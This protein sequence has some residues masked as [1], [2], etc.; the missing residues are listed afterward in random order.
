M[1]FILWGDGSVAFLKNCGLNKRHIFYIFG[2][3]FILIPIFF[4]N[5][6]KMRATDMSSRA[7]T[8]GMPQ[9]SDGFFSDSM[10]VE[11]LTSPGN[12]N[13]NLPAIAANGHALTWDGR[14]FIGTSHVRS[15]A[16]SSLSSLSPIKEVAIGILKS[17]ESIQFSGFTLIM[18]GDG[19]LVLY[20]NG[21][22]GGARWATGTN[23]KCT[24]CMAAFQGDGNLVIYELDAQDSVVKPVYSTRTGDSPGA[25]FLFYS[26]SPYFAIMNE[27]GKAVYW[28]GAEQ[29]SG[30]AARVF[31]PEA[32]SKFNPKGDS[33]TATRMQESFSPPFEWA[34]AGDGLSDPNKFGHVEVLPTTSLNALALIPNSNFTE[35]PFRSDESGR[36]LDGGSYLTYKAFI[37]SQNDPEKNGKYRLG[38]T[39]LT[40]V[41]KNPYSESANIHRMITNRR[42]DELRDVTGRPILAL[43]PTAV[44]DGRLLVYQNWED[45]ANR[46]LLYYTTRQ[47][48]PTLQMGWSAPKSITEMTKDPELH[49]RYP[50]ARYPLRDSRGNEFRNSI[51][52]AYPW[53]SLDGTDL[54]FDYTAHDDGARRAGAVIAGSST[55]GLVR[56]IDGG[57]NNSRRG[58]MGE[59]NS[60]HGEKRPCNTANLVS[61]RLFMS[62]LGRTPGMWSP[63]EFTERKVL[64]FTDKLYT[65]PMF[66]SN[67]SRYF[68]VSLEESVVGNYDLYLEMSEGLNQS[69]DYDIGVTPDVSGKFFVPQL[70]AGVKYAE[71]L[72]AD[73]TNRICPQN[74]FQN[75][76][77]PLFSGKALYFKG[78]GLITVNSTSATGFE[79]LK[80]AEDLTISLAVRPT[81]DLGN[82]NNEYRILVHKP[83][84]FHIILEAN[85]QIQTTVSFK[86]QD[87]SSEEV[88]SGFV[89]P[90]L[91]LNEWSHVAMTYSRAHGVMRTFVNGEVVGE[92]SIP[93]SYVLNRTSS[94]LL[95][96][97]SRGAE[98]DIIFALDQVG[99]SRVVR[100][101][102]ELRRQAQLR[103][104][105]SNSLSQNLPLGLKA[106]DVRSDAFFDRPLNSARVDLGRFLF[107]DKRLSADNRTS[108]ATCHDPNLGFAERIALHPSRM[109]S[110]GQPTHLLRNS[111]SLI[112]LAF[113]DRFFADGRAG[114]LIEQANSV[115]SNPHE[116][117]NDPQVI[118]QKLLGSK[119]YRDLFGTVFPG[120][121]QPINMDNIL[122]SLMEFELSLTSGGSR[123]DR[124]LAGELTALNSEERKG[125]ALFFGKA[126]CA[127]CHSG[128]AFTDNFAHNVGLPVANAFN[129]VDLGRFGFSKGFDD[130]SRYQTPSLRNIDLSAPY[131]HGGSM[132]SLEEVIVHYN[133]IFQ[134]AG[135]GA[136][137]D[138]S[139]IEIGL[140]GSEISSL[141]SFLRALS[142]QPPAV[143]LPSYADPIIELPLEKRFEAGSLILQSN[144]R[145]ELAGGHLVFQTNG[146]LAF[147]DDL[148]RD[149]WKSNSPK[150]CNTPNDC[151]AVWQGDGNLVLY[152]KGKPYWETTT[153]QSHVRGQTLVVSVAN[154]HLK[155]LNS[156]NNLVWS[157]NGGIVTPAPVCAAGSE[158]TAGCSQPSN[159]V[160]KKTCNSQGTAYGSC[161]MT[162]NA[163]YS[164]NGSSCILNPPAQ[165]CSPGSQ[166]T[167]GCTPQPTNGKSERT[168]NSTGTAYGVCYIS[169]NAN[170]KPTNA[171]TCVA[172]PP[173]TTVRIEFFSILTSQVSKTLS[174]L[175]FVENLFRGVLGRSSDIGGLS[176]HSGKL[177]ANSQSREDLRI[178]FV[179]SSEFVLTV[180]PQNNRMW[181]KVLYKSIL[182]RESDQG[183]EDFWTNELDSRKLTRNQVI[184]AFLA[185]PEYKNVTVKD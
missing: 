152:H 155:I 93:S 34:V 144:E 102:A 88:R 47:E 73:C 138:D 108:C 101:Q 125:R 165:V 141:A 121:N 17:Q 26:V 43:E 64:P 111:P 19:N 51:P 128:S 66:A 5:C 99:V 115:L 96:G 131:F 162:C 2:L 95:V 30:W 40:I 167:N 157:S 149:L 164:P 109:G 44:F 61:H 65:Y 76:A 4:Q 150:D 8:S 94:S 54:F 130:R 136:T 62:S 75:P 174:N 69:G 166:T 14:I 145:V 140:N 11:R 148:N 129:V 176:S 48:G 114:S 178:E 92:K 116:M 67:S 41:V 77:V 74:D 160:S 58:C 80:D 122:S 124:Y 123:F 20:E 118:V 147:V 89:G 179:G 107:F 60:L 78:G 27:S 97:S 37:V 87:G 68:E 31:R 46:G 82:G 45:N 143:S 35:N 36:S 119:Q 180:F 70:N 50:F 183:G 126:R 83:D 16:P 168:C 156:T 32:L 84:S 25:R 38:L 181:V 151:K 134:K 153:W 110:F 52:G 105:R 127:E 18:Q 72:F 28:S 177:N 3:I 117:G 146:N 154:P 23:G 63:M 103:T 33:E 163:G 169:C 6:G 137:I 7:T 59:N 39:D 161:S 85:R 79:L 113:R 24:R 9:G 185:H 57:P 158:S 106:K 133:T 139:L 175:D 120:M 86:K 12:S 184:A 13:F 100:S 1:S 56:L 15:M 142:G 22:G 81:K 171:G 159:G 90:S 53:I 91:P 98:S 10:A 55:K 42:F 49:R 71:E 21:T 182:R 29:T 135:N 104:T 173:S 112:N 172:I 132:N 170:F